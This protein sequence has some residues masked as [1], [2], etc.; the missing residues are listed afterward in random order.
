MRKLGHLSVVVLLMALVLT[1]SASAA[2]GFGGAFRCGSGLIYVGDTKAKV[3]RC[4]GEPD[5]VDTEG[6]VTNEVSR[7]A[8]NKKYTRSTTR[9][10]ES[11]TYNRGPSQ[12]IRI[13]VFSGSRLVSI[14]E[15][16]YGW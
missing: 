13:L 1:V 7:R 12:F 9:V 11:W 14:G 5:L 10:V 3:L 2:Y 4:C 6:A 16:D 8:G 15:G